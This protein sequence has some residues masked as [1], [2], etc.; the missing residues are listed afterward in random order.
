MKRKGEYNYKNNDKNDE[1]ISKGI[2]SVS[3]GENKR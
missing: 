2:K 3:L 1:K